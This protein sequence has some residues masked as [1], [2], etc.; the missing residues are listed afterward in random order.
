MRHHYIFTSLTRISDLKE[1]PFEIFQLEKNQWATGDYVICKIIDPGS[2]KLTLELPNGRMRGVMGG[3]LV[4]GVFGERF[5]T[6]EA[7]GTWKKISQDNKLHI[8]TAAGLFGKLTSKSVFIPN[9]TV[10]KY[11]GHA[12][13]SGLKLTMEVF[14]KPIKS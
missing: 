12:F 2:N 11:V 3:E 7:T 4:I 8:L 5:A 6:L 9:L 10:V 1:N 13:R 14:V